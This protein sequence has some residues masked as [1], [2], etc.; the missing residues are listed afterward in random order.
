[1]EFFVIYVVIN[2]MFRKVFEVEDIL[3]IVVVVM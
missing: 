2:G 1:M 3:L